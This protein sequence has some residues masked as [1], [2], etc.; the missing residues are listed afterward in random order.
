MSAMSKSTEE[1]QEISLKQDTILAQPLEVIAFSSLTEGDQVIDVRTP[2]EFM[3]NSLP[4]AVNIPIFDNYERSVIGTMYKQIGRD[5]AVRQGFDFITPKLSELIESFRPYEGQRIVISCARGGMRSRAVA[6]LLQQVGF[7]VAQLQGGYKDYRHAVMET[8]VNYAPPMIVLHGMTGVGKT[9]L[10]EKLHPAID[11][12]G[13]AHHRSSLFG[14][15]DRDP[16]N[17]KTFESLFYHKIIEGPFDYPFVE[18]ESRKIG[19]V[20]MSSKFA[21]AMKKGRMVLVTA[22]LETR[23]QRIIEDYPMDDPEVR[24]KA[25]EVIRTL[26]QRLGGTLVEHLCG[27]LQKD[28]LTDFVHILLTE[29]YDKRYGNSM[30]SYDYDMEISSENVDHA[31]EQLMA[32]RRTII[33]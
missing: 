19:E 21:A 4:K 25:A 32:Y 17:Q 30:K 18:G 20:F 16:H 9:R 2:E 6:N 22:S 33:A 14:A 1:Q 12:E 3:E 28:N 24:E 29:Y 11:L 23:I 27:L 31:V 8:V 15:L 13:M 26:R 5:E 7:E 10:I